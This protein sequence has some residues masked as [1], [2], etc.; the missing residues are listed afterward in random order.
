LHKNLDF[1]II[2]SLVLL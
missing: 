1:G 2:S